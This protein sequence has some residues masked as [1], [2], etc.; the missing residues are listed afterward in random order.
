MYVETDFLLAL[1]KD[2]DWLAE[3]AEALYDEHGDELW[4]SP[5]TLVELLLVA[6]RERMDAERVL[7]NAA[8]LI[9]VRGDVEPVLAAASYV[10]NHGFTPFDAMH[11]VES[12]GDT[13]ASSDETYDEFATTIDLSDYRETG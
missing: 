5:F 13:I 4:T 12:D 2:D 8:E 9:E 3:A 1:A 7:A 11:L 10:E 6:Y